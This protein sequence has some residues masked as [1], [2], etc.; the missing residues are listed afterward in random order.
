MQSNDARI[1]RGAAIPTAVAGILAAP[2]GAVTGGTDTALAAVAGVLVAGAF[3]GSGQL[4]LAKVAQRWPDLLMGA[5]MAVYV[6]KVGILMI[7]TVLLRD[8]SFL[9]GRAFGAGVMAGLVA[10]L[11]GQLW[12]NLR[13]K[14]AYVVPES[15]EP[16]EPPGGAG[17]PASVP[18]S[19]A[20]SRKLP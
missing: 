9:D 1:I 13:V 11:G 18:S 6:A 17:A 20:P 5:A 7:L 4:V 2:A 3:F 12:S 14:T 8:A 16:A 19:A 15:A 10:W